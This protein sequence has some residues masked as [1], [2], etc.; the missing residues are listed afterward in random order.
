MVGEWVGPR[1]YCVTILSNNGLH[2]KVFH[3]LFNVVFCFINYSKKGDFRCFNVTTYFSQDEIIAL[4]HF[5]AN[6]KLQK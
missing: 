6:L 2:E 5:K 4:I 3:H 1:E